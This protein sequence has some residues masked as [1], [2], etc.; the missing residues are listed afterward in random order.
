MRG[1]RRAQAAR[2]EIDREILKT[3]KIFQIDHEF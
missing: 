2:I 1:S 3:G